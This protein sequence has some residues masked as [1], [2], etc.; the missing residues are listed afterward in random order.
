MIDLTL[1]KHQESEAAS[2]LD[3]ILFNTCDIARKH[4]NQRREE[5]TNNDRYLITEI[6][7][8]EMQLNA[9]IDNQP[10]TE[11]NMN[12]KN[13]LQNRLKKFENQHK[14]AQKN[15]YQESYLERIKK[16]LTAAHKP[17]K[18]FKQDQ[19]SR[20]EALKH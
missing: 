3:L 10:L 12:Y 20:A 17:A 7:T 19:R 4:T 15:T 16:E 1:D 2:T 18:D 11:G 9:L 14:E 8:I 5:Q 6:K 13:R